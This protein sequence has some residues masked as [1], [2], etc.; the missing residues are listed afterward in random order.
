VH[1][2]APVP[3]PS[4]DGLDRGSG[5]RFGNGSSVEEHLLNPDMV[6]EIFNVAE[7]DVGTADLAMERG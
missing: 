6:V 2:C 5:I 4:R 3:N 1:L 7:L